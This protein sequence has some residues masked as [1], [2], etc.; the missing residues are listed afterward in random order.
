MALPGADILRVFRGSELKLYNEASESLWFQHGEQG[1]NIDIAVIPVDISALPDNIKV[2]A[3]GD[4]ISDDLISFNAGH[5]VFIVGFPRGIGLNDVFPIWKR[6]SIASEPVFGVEGFP[7]F[8]VDS[9]TREGMSGS[10]VYRRTWNI[11]NYEDRSTTM[12]PGVFTRLL[13]IYSGRYGA[14]DELLAQI[15]R[16]WSV[17]LI[18]DVI[19][20]RIA[21]T[22]EIRN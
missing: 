18:N 13:G 14:N 7:G 15:G 3:Y 10:P 12:S 9:A 19:D 16:V 5:D 11:A 8:L 1:Q 4:I 2:Y 22:Y 17:E 21:G 20:N 6:G